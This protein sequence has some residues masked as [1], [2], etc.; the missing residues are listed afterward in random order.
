VQE[1]QESPLSGV[2]MSVPMAVAFKANL[3]EAVAKIDEQKRYCA[4]LRAIDEAASAAKQAAIEKSAEE[5]VALAQQALD[6]E[7]SRAQQLASELESERTQNW[8]L[9]VGGIAVGAVLGAVVTAVIY[10]KH[11]EQ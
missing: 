7:R 11:Q 8:L 3:D 4:E 5:K 6:A 9:T 2:V 10:S 1:G